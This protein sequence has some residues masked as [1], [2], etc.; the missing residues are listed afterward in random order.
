MQQITESI[1]PLR[2]FVVAMTRLMDECPEEPALLSKG[3]D[4]LKKLIAMDDWLPEFCAQPNPVHYQQYL[5]HSDPL[6]RFSVVSFV[7]E[8]GQRTPIH[9]HTVWGLVGMLR[10]QERSQSYD[11]SADGNLIP[12]GEPILLTQGHVEAVGPS[13]GDIHAVENAWDK[14][15]VSIHVYGANIGAVKRRVFDLATGDMKDFVSGYSSPLVPNLW[16]RSAA[17]RA[18]LV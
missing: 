14:T 16:D 3:T 18:L 7:W 6:E 2:D 12:A 8:P 4:L 1:A 10:G 11:R 9:N 15:S 5:L 17:I 13:I